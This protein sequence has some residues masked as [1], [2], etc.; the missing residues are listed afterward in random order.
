MKLYLLKRTDTYDYDS[1][2]SC[3]VCARS[4]KE[5][6]TITPN[7]KPISDKHTYNPWVSCPSHIS[8][9]EIGDAHAS[10]ERGIVHTSYMAG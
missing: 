10:V 6:K 4:Q 9:T 5:A 3:I 1:Y 2:I 7:G 8:C